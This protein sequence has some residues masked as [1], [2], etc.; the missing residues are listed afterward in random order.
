M[1]RN[2][3]F[4]FFFLNPHYT[5]SRYQGFWSFYWSQ[6][7]QMASLSWPVV[8]RVQGLL[9]RQHKT[10][11]GQR[12]ETPN[13]R[14]TWNNCPQGKILPWSLESN[15]EFLDHTATILPLIQTAYSNLNLFSK[16]SKEN[17]DFKI[18]EY[19]IISSKNRSVIWSSTYSYTS[20]CPY[21]R[22]SEIKN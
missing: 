22:K 8:N 1:C 11:C 21:I 6:Q 14:I 20:T 19:I 2:W 9:L 17:L 10:E 7:T 4:S 3:T 13:P 5:V 12:T 18:S 15:Q 16:K